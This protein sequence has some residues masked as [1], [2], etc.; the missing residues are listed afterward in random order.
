MDGLEAR[1]QITVI[2]ATN[3]P[4]V[5]DPALRRPG[6]FDREIAI[7]IPD[8]NGR[9]EMLEIHTRG[10]PL[11]ADVDTHALAAITHG[12]SGAD[13]AALCREAAMAAVRRVLPRVDFD[14]A[15]FPH[16]ELL[17]VQILTSDFGTALREIGPSALREILVEIPNVTWEDIGGSEDVKRQLR[18]AVE[19]PSEHP[20]LYE[21]SRLRPPRGILLFGPPGT[22]KTLLAKAVAHEF[23][24][25]FIS[26]KGP[27]L[28]SRFVGESEKALREIFRK[29][30]HSSPCV[31]FFDEIDALVPPR[32]ASSSDSHAGERVVA[33]MLSEMDGVEELQDVLVLAAT[34][35]LDRIDPALLRPGRFDYLVKL[36]LPSEEERVAILRVH[37]QNRPLDSSV[38]LSH[39]AGK[40]TGCSG[41]DLEK[42]S[43]EATMNA[44]R[45]FLSTNE[46]DVTDFRIAQGHF[47]AALAQLGKKVVAQFDAASRDNSG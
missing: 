34:N 19:W 10:M 5:L 21:I 44:I 37:T 40:T 43:R 20:E 32:A 17:Q 11:A 35:R 26:V 24:V 42:L 9:H 29:A 28:M 3:L 23:G 8:V 30:R 1:G 33:Q 27:E 12:F 6:R 2:A 16:D 4:N 25:N 14:A 41:A 31:I 45:E 15:Q 13:I 18:E 47:E 22:G 7:G 36:E 38:D 39:L 46:N